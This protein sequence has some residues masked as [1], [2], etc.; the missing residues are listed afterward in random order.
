MPTYA[1]LLNF[2][3]KGISKIQDSPKR[4]DAFR[5]VAKKHGVRVESQ[6]W[7]TGKHDGLVILEAPDEATAS[8]VALGLA[9]LDN[10][11]TT[12]CR[13]FDETEFKAILSKM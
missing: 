5:A 7:L 1:L 9:K 10:V 4:A 3:D 6:Y 2:T 8:A 13:A 12:L 11:R